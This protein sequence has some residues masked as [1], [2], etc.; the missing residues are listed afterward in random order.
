MQKILRTESYRTS[1]GGWASDSHD[2]WAAFMS[3]KSSINKIFVSSIPTRQALPENDESPK[4]AGNMTG[5]E[6]NRHLN[7]DI[8]CSLIVYPLAAVED[9]N[10]DFLYRIFAPFGRLLV[11]RITIDSA[12]Q[13]IGLLQFSRQKEADR[14][15]SEFDGCYLAGYKIRVIKSNKAGKFE[16]SVS[17]AAPPSSL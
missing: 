11:C 3:D 9:I 2:N 10:V 12:G 16:K 15:I 14:V 17:V 6:P 8:N 13:R 7:S 1:P 5:T 4:T